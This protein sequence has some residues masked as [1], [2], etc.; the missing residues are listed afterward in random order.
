MDTSRL[1]SHARVV[2]GVS[3]REWLCALVFTRICV[4]PLRAHAYNAH[5]DAQ[6]TAHGFRPINVLRQNCK[7]ALS[8]AQSRLFLAMGSPL[9]IMR[10]LDQKF[11]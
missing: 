10:I 3:E 7:A 5:G 9:I 6:Q 11:S 2:C 4:W 1:F 8:E